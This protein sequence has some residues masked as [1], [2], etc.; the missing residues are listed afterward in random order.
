MTDSIFPVW[1]KTE[2]IGK[3]YMTIT[4][5]IDGTNALVEVINCADTPKAVALDQYVV[6]V[7]DFMLRAGSRSRWLRPDRKED[8]FGFA[9]W[10][11]ENAHELIKLG[12]GHHY[13][14]WWGAGIQRRYG[15]DHKRFSLFNTNRPPETLPTC[16]HQVPVLYKGAIDL[17]QVS[18]CMDLLRAQ[19]S[20]AAPGWMQPE[21]IVI[22]LN[23][24][25]YKQTFEAGPKG[26]QEAAA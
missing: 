3:L 10:C 11:S 14:E 8:N 16:V 25:R 18:Q 5:K 26:K 20:E 12:V 24:Q 17:A 21:G 23:G 15:L 1:G 13:G 9:A 22:W 7:G 6:R 19:G 2:R 4:E